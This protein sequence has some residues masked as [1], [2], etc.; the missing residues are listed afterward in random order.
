M[1]YMRSARVVVGVVVLFIS[2]IGRSSGSDT[3][4]VHIFLNFPQL[5]FG[6][7]LDGEGDTADLAFHSTSEMELTVDCFRR[8]FELSGAGRISYKSHT[9][10]FDPKGMTMDGS[11]VPTE[12][13]TLIYT[14]EG[15]FVKGFYRNFDR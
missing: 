1:T 3:K 15:K 2:I 13:G 14:K 9:I 8:E 10:N 5:H 4:K 12:E 11:R 6:L 7:T